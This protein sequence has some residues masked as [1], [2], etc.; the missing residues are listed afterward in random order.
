MQENAEQDIGHNLYPPLAVPQPPLSG[1]APATPHAS[2]ERWTPEE[3]LLI[4][5]GYAQHGCKWRKVAAMLQGRSGSS[6]RNRH[7]RLA[8]RLAAQS[9]VRKSVWQE[10]EDL[11]IREMVA[12]VGTQWDAIATQVRAA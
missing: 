2:L 9:I 11:M 10:H 8:K 3:D 4:L 7:G 5:E 6:V 12:A 1:A